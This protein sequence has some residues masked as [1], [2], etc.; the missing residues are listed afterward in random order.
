MY[1]A[2]YRTHQAGEHHMTSKF[3]IKARLIFALAITLSA[4]LC[5]S[6][7]AKESNKSL[8]AAKTKAFEWKEGFKREP[9]DIINTLKDNEV[10]SFN[11]FLEGLPIG[12]DLDKV[13]KG[14][15]PFTLF[16]P[17]DTAFKKIPGEDVQSLFANK[18]KTQQVLKY[19]IVDGSR[20]ESKALR[21]M[22]LV[23]SLEGHEIALSDK[24]GDLYADKALVT[25]SD[26]PCS[27]GVIHVIDHVI[28]PPLKD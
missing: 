8:L 20:L 15:G 3:T 5:S 25:V 2:H 17:T 26:I 9:K 21:A 16:A 27:N 14:S 22:K 11:T 19:H 10:A 4:A 6:A 1:T 23:K 12:F 28:M 24:G 7:N 18:K 13:L